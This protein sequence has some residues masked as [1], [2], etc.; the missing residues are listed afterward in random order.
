[1]PVSSEWNKP[2]RTRGRTWKSM[3]GL[4]LDS[5]AP[6]HGENIRNFRPYWH[7]MVLHAYDDSVALMQY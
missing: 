1:M 7:E 3:E 4:L 2:S 6:G 5:S